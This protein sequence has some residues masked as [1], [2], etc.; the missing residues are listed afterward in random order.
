MLAKQVLKRFPNCAA[1]HDIPAIANYIDPVF[2][3]VHIEA[4]GALQETKNKILI[5]WGNLE[6]ANASNDQV[7][8]GLE[9]MEDDI[10]PTLLLKE[11]K[12]IRGG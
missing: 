12:I 6:E 3:G 4:L 8:V 1:G 9:D 10:D 11:K 2:K 7:D 5:R